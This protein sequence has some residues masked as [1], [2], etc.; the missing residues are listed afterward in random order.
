[1]M[2]PA[3]G[4]LAWKLYVLGIVQLVL[5]GAAV[6]GVGYILRPLRPPPPAPTMHPAQEAAE[7]LK[8]SFDRTSEL[9]S[10]LVELREREGLALTIYDEEQR[11]VATNVEPPL[12]PSGLPPEMGAPSS[13]RL[14]EIETTTIELEGRAY[15]LV[16]GRVP[17]GL[18]RP[19]ASLLTLFLGGLII[20]GIGSF[21]TARWIVRPLEELSRAAR[22]LGAGDL[23]ARTGMKRAD[24]IGDVGRTFDEMAERVQHLLLAERELLANVSHELRTPLARIRVAVDIAHEGDPSDGRLSLSEIGL[25]LTELEAIIDDILTAMRLELATGGEAAS[26]F[27]LHLEEIGPEVICEHASERF[28]V[29]HPRRPL[30]VRVEKDLPIIKADPVLLRR[31]VDN[32][33]ENAHKYSPEPDRPIALSTTHCDE[34]VVFE[35]TDK[36]AGIDAKDLPHVFTAFFRGERSRSRGTGGVG[37]GLT[38]AK[39]IVE[40]H[41]GTI[42]VTS[43]AG[44]GTSVRVVVPGSAHVMR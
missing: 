37:L 39:R 13:G 38:L 6:A 35:V 22:A 29:R 23:R 17:R 42:E 5:L 15:T 20:L 4:T 28:R 16:A 7:R 14:E 26:N 21:W 41:G 36:G 10:R 11:V 33:L 2:R 18:P 25:D 40:A 44:E 19:V 9:A 31:V 8:P 30:D 43:A 3:R 1:M 27:N 32:L 24:E 34:G 12:R